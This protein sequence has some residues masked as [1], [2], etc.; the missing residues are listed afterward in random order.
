MSALAITASLTGCSGTGHLPPVGDCVNVIVDYSSLNPT[1]DFSQ[2]VVTGEKVYASDLLKDA[3]FSI[4][5]T[6]KYPTEIVCRV[7]DFPSATKPLGIKDHETYVEPCTDMPPAFGY[8][9][10]L[11]KPHSGKW[12]WA[13]TGIAEVHLHPGDSVALV[14]S[15]NETVNFPQ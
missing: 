5:G 8:W 1:G 7:N 15:E 9:A 4:V 10:L 6:D 2:C 12:D 13:Q 11:V 14:F 3:G